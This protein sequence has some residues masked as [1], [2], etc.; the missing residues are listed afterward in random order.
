MKHFI[1]IIC[2]LMLFHIDGACYE[3][4]TD[5]RFNYEI[6]QFWGED[7]DEAIVI[8]VADGF[9]PSGQ[10]SFP[11]VINND[12]KEVKVTALGWSNHVG[13]ESDDPVIGGFTGITSVRIPKYMDYI[14]RIEFKDC[15]NIEKYEVEAG[16]KTYTTINGA[17]VQLSTGSKSGG[18]RLVRYPSGAKATSYVVPSPISSISFGAFAA[19]THLRKLVLVGEQMLRTCWQYNNR[20]IETVDCTNSSEYHTDS[21]GAIF[22][23]SMLEGLC[24][25]RRYTKYTVPS[26]VSYM[27]GGVFCNSQVDEVVIPAALSSQ[28]AGSYMFLDSEV[29]R[30]TYEGDA[31]WLIWE[32]AFMG[33][34]NLE[35]IILGAN[36]D[37][38]LRIQTCAFR[39]CE[40]LKTITFSESTK[41]IDIV[42]RA[43]ENCKSL[44]AFP[45]TSKMKISSLGYREF[46]GCESLTS[47]SFSSIREIDTT[48]GFIFAGSGLKEVH[49]PTGK[50]A[51]PRG[52]FADCRNLERVYLKDT[53]TRI[54][55]DAFARSG[56]VA[57]NM[58]GVEWWSWSAFSDCP[59]LVRLY[60]PDNGSTV[61]YHTV[62]FVTESPQIVVNNPKILYL[63]E[64]EECPG[65]ASLYISSVNGGVRIGNGWRTVYVPGQAAD[66]YENLT[67]SEVVEMYSYET[68]PAEGY[69]KITPQVAGVKVTSVV[70]E[71][72]EAVYSGGKFSIGKPFGEN[73]AANIT[74]NYTVFNNPMT[75][76]YNDLYSGIGE[77][78]SSGSPQPE[79]WFTIS[80]LPVDPATAVPGIYIRQTDGKSEKIV[81]R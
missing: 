38:G 62:D 21:D 77:I 72:E 13:H 37:G 4:I 36:A 23:G 3:V 39:G 53:T 14:G 26:G 44:T 50:N 31:P 29:R 49:W 33:C 67:E 11:T 65:V 8:G 79:Q 63:E 47:F 60:F 20:S 55:E 71:G 73:G 24:P 80:G 75:S 7:E 15:P 22:Y 28:S 57:L 45:L 48:Q 19:N 1:C 43:F 42:A 81:I 30:V 51:V 2:A 5:G 40:S 34:R 70:I 74:V 66:L 32:G 16:S 58:M 25:G 69:V 68:H 46:A 59:N 56:L 10:L 18:P 41:N 64:Q 17:L 61:Q 76:T 54:Y 9:I 12:G 35:S 6:V 52:C 27:A 78:R